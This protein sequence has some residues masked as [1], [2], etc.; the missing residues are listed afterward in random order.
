[1][2]KT[3]RTF[4]TLASVLLLTVALWW[5]F[6]ARS[7]EPSATGDRTSIRS[8]GEL[9][10]T[11]RSEPTSYNRYTP[12]GGRAATDLL[13]LLTHAPLVRINRTTDQME[14]WLAESWQ[15]STD[16]LTHTLRLRDGVKFSDGHALTS[17]DVLFSFR[18]VYDPVVKSGLKPNVLVKGKPLAVSAPDAHTVVIA[19]PEPFAPGLRI[20]DV[21]PILP[22]HKLEAALNAGKLVEEWV[23]AKP[24]TDIA[25]L[26]PFVLSEH[27]PGQRLVLTRNAHYFRRD[28]SGVQLPYLDKLILSVVTD[29]NTEALRLEAGEADLMANG[30]IRPQDFAGFKRLADK[31][32]LNL[33]DIGV[34]LDPDFL[35]F[36]LRKERAKDPRASWLQTREFRRAV[37]AGIDRTAI[38]NAVYL[39]AAVPIY[40][41]ISPGNRTWYD[42]SANTGSFD[43]AEARRLLA[44]VGLTD[45]NGDGQLE[46]AQGNPARFS[47]L[48]QGGHNREKVSAVIQEQLR[49]LGLTVDIVTLD[50]GGLFQRWGSGDW[51][52]MYYGL[53]AGSTD[54][55]LN[56]E[57]WLSS[58]AFHFWNPSQPTPA[59]EWER[60][61]DALMADVTTAPTLEA[62]QKAFAEVQKIVV[63]ERPLVHLVALRVTLATSGRVRNPTPALQLPQLL[64]NA[65]SLAAMPPGVNAQSR[66]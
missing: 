3:T 22:K 27:V 36:N 60:R 64:W 43:P 9:V 63:D 61:I 35:A 46:D 33:L 38:V 52:A 49:K 65:E 29:Q 51:D 2:A 16:G 19:F 45:A 20:L 39:G 13:T 44:S 17:E 34:G 37:S 8:G 40:G 47:I 53:Q 55:S 23:P 62:R 12:A 32:R 15:S 50:P 48:T 30:E 11:I 4:V 6:A 42:A 21:L 10:A 59:T 41:P 24:L 7:A 56:T 26:G 54:P 25:G 5:W 18:V 57:L 31:S 1:L 14:P 28:A 66:R 58:G